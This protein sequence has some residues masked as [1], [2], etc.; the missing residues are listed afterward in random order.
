MV[1]V[2]RLLSSLLQWYNTKLWTAIS[3]VSYHSARE[4]Y[5][6]MLNLIQTLNL[7]TK[8]KVTE[9]KTLTLI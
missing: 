5:Q 9:E 7:F 6:L 4:K 2:T 1:K 8:L 3:W